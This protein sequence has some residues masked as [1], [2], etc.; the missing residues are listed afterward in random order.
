[1]AKQKYEKYWS[2]TL[3]YT[4]IYDKNF[5]SVLEAIVKF[6]DAND[7]SKYS[8]ALYKKLQDEVSKINGLKGTSLRK[9]INQFVKLGF[10]NFEFKTY[11]PSSKLFLYAK[12]KQQKKTIFSKIVYENSSFNRDITVDSNKQEISFLIKTLEHIGG[13]SKED[14]A[15]LMTQNIDDFPKGYLNKSELEAAKKNTKE[16]EFYVRKYNQVNHFKSVLSYLDDL[17][18]VDGILKFEEDAHVVL[19][20]KALKD[21]KRKRKDYLHKIY[22]NLLKEESE[23]KLKKT[24]CMVEQLSYPSL[25]ASHIKPFIDSDDNEAYDSQNGLLLSRNMDILFDKGY[26]TFEDDGTLDFVEELEEDVKKHLIKY[27]LDK[28]F[29]T[30]ERLLYLDYHRKEIFGKK[31]AKK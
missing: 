17:V 3:A 18:F 28:Q 24:Q 30:K 21:K 15:A 1:M 4:A 5:N 10:I 11:H 20:E 13:L 7:T 6:I 19:Q 14:I 25:V 9:S 12:L 29:L 26:I 8:P 16:I 2:L 22:K 23:E 31:F 27:K